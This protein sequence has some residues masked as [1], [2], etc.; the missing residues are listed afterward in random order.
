METLDTAHHT[1][2]PDSAPAEA[3]LRKKAAGRSW[4]CP[5]AGFALIGRPIAATLTFAVMKASLLAFCWLSFQPEAP[6]AATLLGTSLAALG[7]WVVEQVAVRKA[8]LHPSSPTLLTSGYVGSTIAASLLAVLA[9]A[10]LVTGFSVLRVGGSGMEPTLAKGTRL[11]YFKRLERD[12]LQPGALIVYRNGED[13]AWGPPGFLM[14]GRILAGPGDELS[15]RDGMYLVNGKESQ[16]ISFLGDAQPV[17]IVPSAPGSI[18]VPGDSHFIVQ[19]AIEGSYDSR[20]L[21][22]VKTSRIVGARQWH[23]SGPRAFRPVE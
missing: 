20:V 11:L 18:T 16:P 10:A 5:G 7:L 9:I 1:V 8:R 15:I 13:S 4:F 6:A 3:A 23:L 14:V 12:R 21:S 17:L 2:H 19:D 22:W